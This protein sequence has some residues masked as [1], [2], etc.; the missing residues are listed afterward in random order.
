MQQGTVR[1]T[2]PKREKAHV[3]EVHGLPI[4]RGT[5]PGKRFVYVHYPKS[6]EF[7][8]GDHGFLPIPKR[9]V[10]VPGCNGIG[11]NGDLTPVIIG[12]TQKGGTYI[13]PTD[14]RLGEYEG[15]VQYYDCDNGQKW[16]CDFCAEATVLPDGEII[17][18]SKPGEWE[19]FRAT[20]R[21]SGIIQPLIPEIYRML[22]EKH[23]KRTE[24]IGSKLNRNPHLQNK[25]DAELKKLE[26]MKACWE[27]MRQEKL[28]VAKT[29]PKAARRKVADPLKA[30]A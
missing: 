16:Y 7:V 26:D 30:R 28:K 20:L 15:Y 14:N 10:A 2:Q 19:K 27:S 1:L 13:D 22:L 8:G 3:R 6:W 11:K 25:Y 24:R 17:W 5:K 18:D 29:K 4:R 21:D 9:V 23:S 12:V